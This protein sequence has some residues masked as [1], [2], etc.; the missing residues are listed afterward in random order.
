MKNNLLKLIITMCF[1]AILFMPCTA[2]ASESNQYIVQ[3]ETIITP[4]SDVIE[5]RI[6]IENNKIYK[7]LYNV[8]TKEWIGD[9][10]YVGE[11][12]G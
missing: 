6:K 9:W 11:Y 4:K 12:Q 7:R 3:N 2:W 10:I 1:C 8:T 5:W